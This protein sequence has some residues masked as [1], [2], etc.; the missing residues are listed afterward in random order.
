MIIIY[1][2]VR[3]CLCGVERL[4]NLQKSK[5]L[6]CGHTVGLLSVPQ[7]TPIE[8][9]FHSYKQSR[10]NFNRSFRDLGEPGF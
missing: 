7:G 3:V 10:P 5:V 1:F 9:L 8:T 6:R 2:I 4:C